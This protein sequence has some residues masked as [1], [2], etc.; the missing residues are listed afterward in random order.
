MGLPISDFPQN[1]LLVG[2]FPVVERSQDIAAAKDAAMVAW[3][4]KEK[5]SA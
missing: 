5:S 4:A 2:T 1:R 3:Q